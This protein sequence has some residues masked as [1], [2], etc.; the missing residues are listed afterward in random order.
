MTQA[1]VA[2]IAALRETSVIIAA[3]IGVWFLKEGHLRQRLSGAAVV[4]ASLV[5]LKL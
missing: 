1:P 2:I 4:L 5:A 3:L